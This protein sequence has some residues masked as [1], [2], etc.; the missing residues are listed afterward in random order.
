MHL[1]K[2]FCL[3]GLID[4][5]TLRINHSV[6]SIQIT[7]MK[8]LP[9]C[10]LLVFCSLAVIEV[11]GQ[12]STRVSGQG[13]SN[14][15]SSSTDIGYDTVFTK[16]QQ[17]PQF[18]GGAESWKKY[19]E[20]NLNVSAATLGGVSRGT[21]NVKVQFITDK[22]GNVSNVHAIAPP[23]ECPGCA[24]EAIKVIKKGPKWQPAVQ[25]RRN[26]IFQNVVTINFPVKAL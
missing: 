12:G 5:C 1:R 25:N 18:P 19:L 4:C 8:T 2:E 9:V 21:Y 17:P 13:S 7:A 16:V 6:L 11:I 14:K 15:A 24:V 20:R 10:L 3:Q 23:K 26:V 22:E